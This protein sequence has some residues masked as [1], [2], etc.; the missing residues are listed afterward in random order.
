M[1]AKYI[2]GT[3][4]LFIVLIGGKCIE[5]ETTSSRADKCSHVGVVKDLTGLD[6]CGYVI[7]SDGETFE[8][9]ELP[10]GKQLFAGDSVQFSYTLFDG[11]SICMVGK[12]IKVTCLEVIKQGT[13]RC[14]SI[15]VIKTDS[16]K[17]Q[18][19]SSYKLNKY[20]IEKDKLNLNIS[21]SGCSIIFD[22]ELYVS[23]LE[24]NSIPPQRICILSFKPQP[25]EA[26]LTTNVCFD[27]SS[28]E[29]E[30]VLL[31]KTDDG[32]EKIKYSP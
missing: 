25:C 15:Q 24:I 1:N 26:Y 21:Y 31:L 4:L 29:Y 27:L 19:I 8:V 5:K 2:L 18:P 6:G 9:A 32:V 20:E 10:S 3:L 30:T 11:A 16:L 22:Q 12:Q 17:F 13:P 7:E 28:I 14:K 23:S